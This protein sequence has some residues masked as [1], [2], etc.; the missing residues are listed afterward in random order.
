MAPDQHPVEIIL[1]RGFMSNL[2]T[3]AFLVDCDGTLVFFN[4]PAGELLG[5]D[6]EDAGP[7]PAAEWGV[8]FEPAAPDGSPLAPEELP[9]SIAL[10]AG[11]PAHGRLEIR[12]IGE[13]RRMIEAVAFP[14]VGRGGQTGAIAIFWDDP[15]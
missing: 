12:P 10:N 5:L 13:E 14:I 15:S 9:L 7:M 11:R 8:R 6:F 1:A 2:S 3:A 4:E